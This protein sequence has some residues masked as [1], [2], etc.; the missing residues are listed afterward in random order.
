MPERDTVAVVEATLVSGR[1]WAFEWRLHSCGAYILNIHLAASLKG[2][3]AGATGEENQAK[4]RGLHRGVLLLH[5]LL[6]YLPI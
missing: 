2:E 3:C 1:M 5:L 6:P 4:A